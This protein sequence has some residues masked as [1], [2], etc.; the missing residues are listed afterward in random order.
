MDKNTIGFRDFYAGMDLD[1]ALFFQHGFKPHNPSSQ[2]SGK[3]INVRNL[4]PNSMIGEGYKCYGL[5][6]VFNFWNEENKLK[7]IRIYV[8]NYVASSAHI[9]NLFD[10]V[11]DDPVV[12]LHI[13]HLSKKYKKSYT[14]SEH[15]RLLFNDGDTDKLYIA[16][17]DGQVILSLE[18]V[19]DDNDKDI[20]VYIT[21]RNKSD[22]LKFLNTIKPKTA[23]SDF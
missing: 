8:L 13:Y 18:R 7:H 23:T 11:S 14:Y 5:D 16:Y 20:H 4:K 22:G 15:Q 1:M 2:S 9:G 3:C 21:Y 17:E 12:G 6:Y 10:F 19:D